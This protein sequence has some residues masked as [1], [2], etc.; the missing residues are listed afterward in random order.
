MTPNQFRKLALGIAGAIESAHM[1]HP[2]FRVEGKIFASL[3]YPGVE[4]A[5][6][7][8][9]PEQ[10]Q[11]F[12]RES[13]KIFNPCKGVWG[14]RGATNMH[15]PSATIASARIALQAASRNILSMKMSPKKQG[16]RPSKKR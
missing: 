3:G 1:D 2:D 13:P 8:L 15:L 12:V 5:M 6:V 9:T 16:A 14:E 10:Q 7:K 11:S 4:W